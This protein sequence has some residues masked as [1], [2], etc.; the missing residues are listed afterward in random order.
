MAAAWGFGALLLSTE[1]KLELSEL[2]IRHAGEQP[3]IA[4]L[5]TEAFP[6]PLPGMSLHDNYVDFETGGWRRWDGLLAGPAPGEG[7]QGGGPSAP[8]AGA[9][10]DGGAILIPTEDTLRFAFLSSQLVRREMPVCLLGGTGTG[11]TSIM[12]EILDKAGEAAGWSQGQLVLSATIATRGLQGFLESKLEKQRMGIYGPKAPAKKLVCFLDDLG[13]P[14]REKYG[15]QP[16]LELLRALLGEGGLYDLK[17]TRRK[18]VIDVILVGAMSIPTGGRSFPTNRLLRHFSLVCLPELSAK[19]MQLVFRQILDLGLLDHDEAW[20]E[21]TGGLTEMSVALYL[22]V[23]AALRP[24]PAK[25]HYQ[26][27]VR[28]LTELMQGLLMVKASSVT[29]SARKPELL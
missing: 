6:V 13:M 10:A 16:P 27:N 29:E 2:L 11:K 24:T 28:Q 15:A 25:S 17:T 26:F 8:V 18:R 3:E 14:A 4:A 22:Q 19:T 5:A 1:A 9:A 23:S 12:K 7:G 21:R 20:R